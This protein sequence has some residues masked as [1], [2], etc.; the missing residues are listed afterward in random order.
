M[1]AFGA[2]DG[3]DMHTI[4]G[5]WCFCCGSIDTC[6]SRDELIGLAFILKAELDL[7]ECLLIHKEFVTYELGRIEGCL[8]AWDREAGKF[9][10]GLVLFEYRI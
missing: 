9:F 4:H 2:Q 6:G 7:T 5:F 8:K 1:R 3:M 10:Q